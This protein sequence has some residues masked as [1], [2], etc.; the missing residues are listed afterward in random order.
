M[1]AGP[2]F[3]CN[4][5]VKQLYRQLISLFQKHA[6]ALLCAGIVNEKFAEA[7]SR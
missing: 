6:G 2:L 5:G 4:A 3:Q 1:V 7:I